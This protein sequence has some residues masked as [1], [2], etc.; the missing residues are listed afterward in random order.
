M[1]GSDRSTQRRSIT[2]PRLA[3]VDGRAPRLPAVDLARLSPDAIRRRF[4]QPPDWTPEVI[5]DRYRA[6]PDLPRP[7]AVLVSDGMA[8]LVQRREQPEELLRYDVL[9]AHLAPIT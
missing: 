4:H 3:P 5:D 8:E 1:S 7:A 6:S 2:D 9:P